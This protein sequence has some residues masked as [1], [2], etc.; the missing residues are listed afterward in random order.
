LPGASFFDPLR[1]FRWRNYRDYGTGVAGDLFV[2]LFS[3]LHLVTSSLGSTY[4]R[5]LGE[6]AA[7]QRKQMLPPA[8]SV[9]M[10]E[11]RYMGAHFDHFMN[12]FNGVR[13]GTPVKE[14]AVLG[15]RAA[16][17]ALAN[18]HFEK[19]IMEWDPQEMR[20]L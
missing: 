10:A 11:R 6:E 8:E 3:S 18:S 17:P 15:L 14:D 2:H 13:N 1:F 19:R 4:L 16:A 7:S 5:L 20:V 12:F 9:W